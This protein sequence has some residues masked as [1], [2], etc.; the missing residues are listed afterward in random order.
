MSVTRLVVDG[1]RRELE[2][3]LFEKYPTIFPGGS[4]V[5]AQESLMCFGFACGDGWFDLI[6]DLCTEIEETGVDVT[7]VQVKE[8]FGGLRF[9]C[10]G[11]SEGVWSIIGK[12]EEKSFKTCELCGDS[13]EITDTGWIKTLCNDC[14]EEREEKRL[15]RL[16]ELVSDD[17]D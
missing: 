7:A 4:D 5:D 15:A 3:E 9:Y 16:R 12:Y 1:M 14:R 11:G 8:K 13:G 10:R 2:N 17:K 6:D